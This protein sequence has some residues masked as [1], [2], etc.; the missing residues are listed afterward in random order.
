[1]NVVHVSPTYYSANSIIGG[2][3]KYI[4]YMIRAVGRAATRA[5]EPVVNSMLAF[6]ERAGDHVLNGD[7]LCRVINGVPWDPHSIRVDELRQRIA[8]ADVVVVHQCLSAFGL[9]VASHAQLDG[10]WVVGMDHG[11]G[12][13]PLVTHS[14]E[15]AG[16][17]NAFWAQSD[18][19]SNAFRGL[20]VPT[21][22]VR[23][24]VDTDYYRPES[25]LD[26]DRSL[27]VAVGRLL[28]HKGFDRIIKSMPAEL[29][30]IIA[31]GRSDEDYFF[32]LDD[33]RRKAGAQVEIREGLDDD[34]VRA[35]L[36]KASLFVHASTH[37]DYRGHYYPK[38]ELLG[39]APLEALACGTPTFVSTAGSL[40]E[41]AVV[42]GCRS[43][44]SDDELA[45]HL[46]AHAS[47]SLAHPAP[48]AIHASVDAA[49]GI[50]Q[51]GACLH[52][53]LKARN[54]H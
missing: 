49:Y 3:E 11:G 1:M 32:H 43:F 22:V 42:D 12:E 19:A 17:Y 18:F 6:G 5:K 21:T 48:D 4:I 33:L 13:H 10:K 31:G 37:T 8:E 52:A 25:R 24:P 20:G 35:L 40:A 38:P 23:G 29:K 46:A 7:I 54:Q 53:E 41:L 15:G 9:F 51:F 14:P 34:Q 36:R 2:G 26:K 47:R 44:A 50:G 39:L 45:A 30:L 27:V 28:P 16:M